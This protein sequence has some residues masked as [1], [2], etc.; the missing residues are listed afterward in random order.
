MLAHLAVAQDADVAQ[1]AAVAQEAIELIDLDGTWR[2]KT[3]DDASWAK[4]DFDDA[5]WGQIKVP[6]YWEKAGYEGVDGVA[7]Y[8]RKVDVPE[9]WRN[10]PLLLH[11]G[12]ISK[13][14]EVFVNGKKIGQMGSF[15]PDVVERTWNPR[16]YVVPPSV[17]KYGQP[18]VIAVRVYD[19]E[20]GQKGGIWAKTNYL[21]PAPPEIAFPVRLTS[22]QL[23]HLFGLDERLVFTVHVGNY[24]VEGR[25]LTVKVTVKNY[26]NKVITSASQTV[27]VDAEQERQAPV[28]FESPGFGF[29]RVETTLIHNGKTLHRNHTT[30]GVLP[31]VHPGRKKLPSSY[32]GIC[33]HLN[34]LPEAHRQNTLRLTARAGIRWVRSGFLWHHIEPSPG[35]YDWDRYDK[36]IAETRSWGIQVLPV[37]AFG[38]SWASTAPDEIMGHARRTYMPK[39]A[40]WGEFVRAVMKRYGAEC[41]Y[42]EVWNEPNAKTFW[43][44][45]S[46]AAEQ[47][48]KLMAETYKVAKSVDPKCTVLLGGFAPKHWVK[49][50]PESHEAL[51][52]QMLYKHQPAPFDAANIHPY[53]SPRTKTPNSRVV[54]KLDR[55][56]NDTRGEMVKN[57]DADKPIWVTEF[58]VPT[59]RTIISKERAA[60]YLAVN[61]VHFLALG[62]VPKAFWYEFRDGGTNPS[63]SEH[64]FGLLHQD[65][66][67][68]PAYFTYYTLTRLLEGA[69]FIKQQDTDG[70]AIHEFK[71]DAGKLLV[72]WSNNNEPAEITLPVKAARVTITDVVG[73][74]REQTI[75]GGR[76]SLKATASPLFVEVGK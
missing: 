42:W 4:A 26:H 71:T 13:A 49:K 58:G 25:T 8:R 17:V 53:A 54:A 52:M 36:I 47:F 41:R 18:N 12:A 56:I 15:P 10:K 20:Y 3:G 30:F 69:R 1:E 39:L 46:K 48:A 43:K 16:D 31:E 51:F 50:T 7:W 70:V 29:Y 61:M 45:Q 6:A 65:Y 9:A 35:K 55:I 73:N 68:K 14:D 67:P 74:S 11:F 27:K 23:G 76:L 62:Y 2:F 21:K 37:L 34:R 75:E 59:R 60:D 57:G 22:K 28:E 33:G 32:F 64:H 5:D 72:L 40:P 66:T 38:A 24:Q 44:P 19:G 63:Y